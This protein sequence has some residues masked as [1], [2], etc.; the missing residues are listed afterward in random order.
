MSEE[1][2]SEQ[3][4]SQ[5]AFGL[6]ASIAGFARK[7]G[8]ALN[9]STLVERF[10]ATTKPRLREALADSTLIHGSRIER[11]FEATVLSLGRFKLLKVEDVGLRHCA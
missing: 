2:Q 5:K 4:K 7:N 10:M 3:P 11:L 6:L 9:D 1:K 8:I